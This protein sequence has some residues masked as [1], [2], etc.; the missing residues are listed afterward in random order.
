MK[1]VLEMR[2]VVKTHRPR[3]RPAVEALRS[4]SLI[5]EPGS[6]KLVCGPSGSGK[7]T[8]LLTAGGLERPDAGEVRIMGER[9]DHRS[10]EEN[11]RIR[12]ERIGFVFQQFHLIPFLNVLEN[13]MAPALALPHPDAE[14]EARRLIGL[15]GLSH[16]LAH[17]PS[18]LSTGERQ[19]VSLARAMLNRPALILADEP[20]GNLDEANAATVLL[21][22]RD[23]A[24]QGGAVLLA[25]HD[26]RMEAD[27]KLSLCEGVLQA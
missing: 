23:F 12:A 7:T 6:F 13:V 17:P 3:G 14:R 9:I 5:L 27:E 15:F 11:A 21:H 4:I 19:R 20:T 18:E 1:P 8:L 22:L 10:A 24:A 2:G 16:R 26:R 25:T